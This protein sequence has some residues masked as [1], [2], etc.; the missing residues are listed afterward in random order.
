MLEVLIISIG[1]VLVIEGTVY[2]IFANKLE[3]IISILKNF[4]PQ[5]IKTVSLLIAFFGLCLIYFTFK[6]YGE[7]K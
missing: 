5:K 6:F 2:F 4:N 1:L 7:F 3:I